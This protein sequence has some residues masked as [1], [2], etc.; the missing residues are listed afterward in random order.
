M[1]AEN[2][3]EGGPATP[4]RSAT[5]AP[6]G[7]LGFAKGCGTGPDLGLCLGAGPGQEPGQ[8]QDGQQPAPPLWGV[9]RCG[10]PGAHCRLDATGKSGTPP[11]AWVT[12]LCLP[13]VRL[14]TRSLM[15]RSS[16]LCVMRPFFW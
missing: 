8:G 3:I 10:W 11:G 16:I 7:A 13:P 4:G 14:L 1:D 5:F 15:Y 9:G 6:D 2:D 12:G